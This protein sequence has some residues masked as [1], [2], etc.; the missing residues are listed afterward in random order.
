MESLRA[1]PTI[2]SQLWQSVLQQL[3]LAIVT[4]V[5]PPG[6][7]LVEAELANRLAVSRGPVREVLTRLEHEGLIV[8]CPYRG[9]PGRCR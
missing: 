5:L 6:S 2:H 4:G 7:H 8:N 1:T 3:R 9:P